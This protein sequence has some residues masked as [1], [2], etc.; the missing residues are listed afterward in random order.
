MGTW[1]L[2]RSTCS[3]TYEYSGTWT[4]MVRGLSNTRFFQDFVRLGSLFLIPYELPS[5]DQIG[6][7]PLTASMSPQQVVGNWV[8]VWATGLR[9]REYTVMLTW[10]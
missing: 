3:V 6:P 7:S 10:L 1:E 5:Q 2:G 9:F 4:H 8:R